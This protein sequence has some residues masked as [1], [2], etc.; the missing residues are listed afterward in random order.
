MFMAQN[1]SCLVYTLY[2]KTGSSILCQ[3]K[4]SKIPIQ[5]AAYA[6][7]FTNR[8]IGNLSDHPTQY[9]LQPPTHNWNT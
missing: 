5:N 8:L 6:E 3:D 7:S 9:S 1:S 2:L 4:L